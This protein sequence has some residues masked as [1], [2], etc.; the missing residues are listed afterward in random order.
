MAW[1]KLFV[2]VAFQ[3]HT[4]IQSIIDPVSEI[5]RVGMLNDEISKS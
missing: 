5:R 3:P 2:S 1:C 4:T